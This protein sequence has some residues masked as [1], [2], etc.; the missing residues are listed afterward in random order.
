MIITH[1]A[2]FENTKSSR[3]DKCDCKVPAIMLY[4]SGHI[5]LTIHDLFLSK[6][7][8][9]KHSQSIGSPKQTSP[10]ENSSATVITL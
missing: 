7:F 1:R 4:L 9:S 10:S 6:E 8:P 3:L 2:M 5:T